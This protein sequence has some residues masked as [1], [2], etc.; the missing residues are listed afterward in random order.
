MTLRTFIVNNPEAME[1]HQMLSSVKALPLH[2][3][4]AQYLEN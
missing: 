1:I 2:E 4:S 3:L